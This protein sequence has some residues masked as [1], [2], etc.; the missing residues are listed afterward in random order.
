MFLGLL[1]SLMA[2]EMCFSKRLRISTR[3][4]YA[5]SHKT[6][7]FMFVTART[8][9]CVASLVQIPLNVFHLLYLWLVMKLLTI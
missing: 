3:L 9:K 1:L 2:K 7:I 6:L 5:T 8:S 4:N